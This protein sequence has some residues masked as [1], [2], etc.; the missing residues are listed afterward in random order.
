[1][2]HTPKSTYHHSIYNFAEPLVDDNV[3]E[4][5][6]KLGRCGAH[7]RHAAAVRPCADADVEAHV[8]VVV[9]VDVGVATHYIPSQSSE[10]RS[11]DCLERE[12]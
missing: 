7:T 9:V 2:R 10:R 11:G 3:G 12:L 5:E 4:E 1:M 6:E 8:V